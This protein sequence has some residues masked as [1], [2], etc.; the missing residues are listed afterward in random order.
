[1]NTKWTLV[2]SIDL[3]RKI[4][5]V[6]PKFFCHVALT[7]GVLYKEGERKDLDI[8]FYRIRQQDEIDFDGLDEA[9]GE[10]GLNYTSGFGWC[11]KYKYQGKNIDI[12][13]PEEEGNEY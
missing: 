11:W 4:E 12:F 10:L 2:E 7:G 9:L 8:L 1:M 6:C 3:C 5:A 13:F